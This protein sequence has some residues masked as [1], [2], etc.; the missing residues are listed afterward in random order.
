MLIYGVPGTGKST[1]ARLCADRLDVPFY[2]FDLLR[3]QLPADVNDPYLHTPSTLAWQLI[4]P[5]SEVTAVEG[6]MHVRQALRATTVEMIDRLPSDFV[7]ESAFIDP[8]LKPTNT[9][10]VI[11]SSKERHYSQFFVHRKP[12]AGADQ[13]F[14]ASRFIQYRLITEADGL[15]I[16]IIDNN[17]N[18]EDALATLLALT[19]S[20]S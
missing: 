13:Q 9:I 8:A 5:L 6:F 3:H 4:G 20:R 17:A 18:T 14:E 12:S 1:I 2:E 11:N 7:A 10:L 16:P 19:A 15:H